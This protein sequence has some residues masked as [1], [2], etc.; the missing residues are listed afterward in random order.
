MGSHTL[1][2]ILEEVIEAQHE[3][4]VRKM[5]KIEHQINPDLPALRLS[6]GPMVQVFTNLL[7]NA[8]SYTPPGGQVSF[9]S[10]IARIKGGAYVAIRIHNDGPPISAEDLPHIFD[11]FYR[12]KTGR[13]SGQPGTGLGLAICKEIVERH[14]GWMEVESTGAGTAFTVWLPMVVAPPANAANPQ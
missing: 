7:T 9:S 11:R 2:T 13:E 3:T 4:A 8:V 5:L 14:G 6:R 10:R 1:D 12:G